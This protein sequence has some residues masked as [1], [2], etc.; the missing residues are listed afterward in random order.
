MRSNVDAWKRLQEADY[1]ERHRCYNGHPDQGPIDIEYIE[2]FFKLQPDQVVVVV[3]CGYGRES[4]Y[5]C[6]RVKKVYGIDVCSK[7]LWKAFTYLRER[8][9]GNFVPIKVEE[10]ADV[11]PNGGV[12]LVYSIVVFQHLT[13]DLVHDYLKTLGRKL[14]PDG[15]MVLQY[16]ETE[17]G[18]SDADPN[19]SY[20]P[21]VSWKPEQIIGA[22]QAADLRVLTLTT[23][24][25]RS[26]V[27]WHWAHLGRA[28]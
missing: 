9:I 27:F 22:A 4:A 3:G 19:A 1:F 28:V 5:I 14:A 6:P 11:I 2:P 13:R 20:E 8:G 10:Y 17:A 21:A 7:I 23:Q 16:L 15:R 12:D 24:F 26:G 18:H 25:I